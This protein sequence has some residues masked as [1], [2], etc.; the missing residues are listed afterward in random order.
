MTGEGDDELAKARAE[1][2]RR[3]LDSPAHRK[4]VVAGPGTGKTYTFG[5][6]FGTRPRPWL[7]L[8]FL[9]VLV[10]DLDDAL[11]DAEVYSFHG[12]ARHLL[13]QR[14]I[15]GVTR[16]AHYF[17]LVSTLYVEDI[18]LREGVDVST[19]ELGGLFRSLAHDDRL[20]ARAL[21]SG[22]YYDAVGHDD[23]VYRV[24]R[25]LE[26]DGS[27]PVYGQIVVDEYQ[28]FSPLEVALIEVLA[29]VGPTLIA[30]DDDQALYAFRDATPAAIRERAASQEWERFELPFCTRCTRVLVAAT[31]TVV[32]RA[33][34]QGL[35]TGR[36]DKQYLCFEPAKRD[37]SDR[38][39]TITHVR[40]SVQ[41][42]KAPYMSRYI[43]EAIRAI[44]PDEIAESHREGFP[45]VLVIAPN[46]FLGQIET[47]L[48]TVFGNVSSRNPS[49]LDIDVI[50]GHRL[51]V[52]N[53]H[54]RLGWRILLHCLRPTGWEKAIVEA[55]GTG[56]DLDQL[57]SA[58]FRATQLDVVAVLRKYVDDE[59]LAADEAEML[60]RA[61]G[62]P[63]R[64]LPERVHPAGEDSP[65]IDPNEPTILLTTLMGSKG[66]QAQHVF[67]AGLNDEHFPRD[68]AHP[69]NEEVCQ[70][71]VA[72]TRARK[73][74]VLLSCWRLAGL[75]KRA[76]IF[77]KWLA[78][79]VSVIEV[80]KD[81]F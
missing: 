64:A 73:R 43:E 26:S 6:L 52:R 12:F 54:S 77:T 23:S 34:E 71:L 8:T 2:L 38:Y 17:P 10:R 65:E 24:L 61:L 53:A 20:L 19:L 14:T 42:A 58:E 9:L 68:N 55:L 40:C 30:G 72:L 41:T 15:E 5:Q 51:L 21:E 74:C 78:P 18:W 37:D 39:P 32:Q 46:P 70:L 33:Q 25:H 28:D 47:H 22:S 45:T 31:H 80:N 57:I 3:I 49:P 67:V 29:N 59:Q 36:I 60:G 56:T 13:H 75:Q 69:T 76:S 63:P 4:L 44:D 50:D 48:R 62:V 35:L 81:Y 7:A 16:E 11:A 66:L 27:V 79:H 1:Y